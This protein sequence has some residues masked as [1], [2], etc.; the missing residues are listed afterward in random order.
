MKRNMCPTSN[1]CWFDC[2]APP[3]HPAAT[4]FMRPAC[5]CSRS[6][7]PSAICG[8]RRRLTPR[9]R[10]TSCTAKAWHLRQVIVPVAVWVS[11]YRLAAKTKSCACLETERAALA[12]LSSPPTP[13]TS[14]LFV[15]VSVCLVPRL[16]PRVQHRKLL[17]RRCKR[18]PSQPLPSPTT[19]PPNLIVQHPPLPAH[20]S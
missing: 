3:H 7:F 9:K 5:A 1:A 4:L 18:S 16:C 15:T 17:R 14:R 12:V 2:P 11:A 20:R 10:T 19:S 13:S 6:L 8:G